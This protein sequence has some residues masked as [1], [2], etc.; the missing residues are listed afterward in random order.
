MISPDLLQAE[1]VSILRADATVIAA[2]PEV[3][4]GVREMQWKGT[5]F[6]YPNVR[7]QRPALQLQPNGGSC[8]HRIADALVS[9]SVH[10]KRDSSIIAQQ[11]LG[12]VESALRG[13][14]ITTAALRATQLYVVSMTSVTPEGLPGQPSAPG[15]VWTGTVSLRTIVSPI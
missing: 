3:A 4:N 15:E 1:I 6:Q 7:V 5:A 2:L 11:I 13:R 9:I 14:T 10:S 8:E 12:F